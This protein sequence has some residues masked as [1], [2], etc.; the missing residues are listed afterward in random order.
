MMIFEYLCEKDGVIEAQYPVGKAA[1]TLPCPKC[2]KVCER[3]FGNYS[4]N[5]IL[6]GGGWPGKNAALNKQMNAKQDKAGKAMEGTWRKSV[7][8]LIPN[9]NGKRI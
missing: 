6:K 5:F 2:G 8:K 4:G 9:K 7:P 1:K 3:Y